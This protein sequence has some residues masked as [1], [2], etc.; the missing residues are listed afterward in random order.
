MTRS[1]KP[2]MTIR[3]RPNGKRRMHES[4]VF[5]VSIEEDCVEA[6]CDDCGLSIEVHP[7][8]ELLAWKIVNGRRAARTLLR[9][10]ARRRALVWKGSYGPIVYDRDDALAALAEDA[11]CAFPCAAASREHQE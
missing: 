2:D 11:M 3:L 5:S 6:T 9:P 1:R 10:M 7:P 8:P 4:V